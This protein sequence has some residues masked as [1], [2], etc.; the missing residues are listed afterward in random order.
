[1]VLLASDLVSLSIAGIAAT[2]IRFDDLGVG[3]ALEN[4]DAEVGF[5]ELSLLVV[6]IWLVFLWAE[7]LYDLDRLSWGS[8]EFTRVARALSLGIVGVIVL[9]YVLKLPGLSRGWLL[10]YWVLAL[11]LVSLGR[12]VVRWLTARRHRQGK[13]LKP[14]LVVGSNAEAADII[15]ILKGARSQGLVPVAGLASSQAERLALDF[16][17]PDVPCIGFAREVR[18]VVKA[19]DID[20]VIIVSSAF[21]HDILA[22]MIAELRD[23]SVDVHISSGLF[24]VMTRRVLVREIGGV[25]LITVKG[26]SLSR[27][28]LLT[29]RTFDI[30]VSAAIVIVGSPFWL[31]VILSIKLTSPGP[32]FFGQE[33]VGKNGE[34]FSMLKFRS[35]VVDAE[36][37]LAKLQAENEASGPLFKMKDDPRVTSIGRWM[38]KYSIDEFP[39]VLNVLKGEMS[40]VGPRPPLPRETVEYTEYHWR[41]L[42]VVPGMTGLWQVSGRSSLTFEE[43]IR[44]DVFYI[45]NWSLGLD[46]SLIAR[47]VPAVVLAKGAY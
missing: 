24:E 15:R 27:A 21:D 23:V 38:R 10:L 42:E 22:R 39:Q 4:T 12:A 19:N 1:L 9:T 46:L 33:R 40:L 20:T 41:R 34:H 45:E 3:V 37:Q 35:M 8:A 5:L 47:T 28:N 29:K 36:A 25:P 26:I 2:Y 31:F 32:I 18:E 7:G 44:L 16:C 13:D 17:A 6:P 30:I 11:V 14:T 43:M